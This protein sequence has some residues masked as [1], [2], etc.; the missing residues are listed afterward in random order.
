[1]TEVT[2]YY[3]NQATGK[4][5]TRLGELSGVP[6]HETAWPVEPPN[7][8]AGRYDTQAAIEEPDGRRTTTRPVVVIV[9]VDNGP[10]FDV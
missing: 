5:D 10:A 3:R 1:M 9:D 7:L 6:G 8:A 2:F 4:I